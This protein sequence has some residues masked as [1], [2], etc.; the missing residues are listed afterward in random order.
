MNQ[1]MMLIFLVLFCSI[2]IA[3]VILTRITVTKRRQL[4]LRRRLDDL[5]GDSVRVESL[6]LNLTEKETGSVLP[7]NFKETLFWKH[8]EKVHA[9][10]G[11]KIQLNEM[12]SLILFSAAITASLPFA[13]DLPLLAC[14][15]LAIAIVSIPYAMLRMKA[16]KQ[17][18]Q[19]IMQLPNAIDLMVSTLRS[20]H[21]IPISVRCV[22]EECPAPCGTEFTQIFHK[23]NLGQ[24]LPEALESSVERFESF[25]LDLIRRASALHQE[26]GGSLAE[27]LDKTNETL[28]Q[29]IKLKNQISIMTT[30]GKLSA[31]VCALL[32]VVIA[33]IFTNINP[34]YLKPLLESSLGQI[35]LAL[36]LVLDLSGFFIMRRLSTFRI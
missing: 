17:R 13:L 4:E 28:R 36:A 12:L 26:V 3:G 35:L 30:Q 11:V 33:V 24:G 9:Q 8:L 15:L 31:L 10:S 34:D 29:R 2:A 1:T 32:P 5:I 27:I 14:L 20:G 19:F 25:E 23:M 7:A 18:N 22:A 16:D 21:S 6:P